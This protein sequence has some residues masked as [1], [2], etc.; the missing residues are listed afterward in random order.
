MNEQRHLP[1]ASLLAAV[2][3]LSVAWAGFVAY[4]KRQLTM[5][6][7]Q[8][9][10][11]LAQLEQ[12][13]HLALAQIAAK[14]R[15]DGESSTVSGPSQVYAVVQSLADQHGMSL[16]EVMMRH[17]SEDNPLIIKLTGSYGEAVG[18]LASLSAQRG[19]QVL[20]M[21]MEQASTGTEA[22]EGQIQLTLGL[23]LPKPGGAK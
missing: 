20:R 18:F 23:V 3:I 11:E 16:T 8:V 17:G 13:Q 12:E 10:T 21:G 2:L 15:L 1:V 22:Y 14:Q 6:A 7:R 5:A 4:Q 9:Q 19:F